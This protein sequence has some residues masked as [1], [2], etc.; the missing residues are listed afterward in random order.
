MSILF[1]IFLLKI[2]VSLIAIVAPFLFWSAER[3]GARL[4]IDAAS[5]LFFRLY[6][7]A[8]LALL[9]GYAGGAVE[10]WRGEFPW[11]IVFMG[12]VSNLG[13]AMV[14]IANGG[15]K[16]MPFSTVFFGGVGAALLWAA[17]NPA[18]SATRLIA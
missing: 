1:L 9:V 13:G 3:I 17:L 11:P 5:P 18:A 2:F 7:I 16:T 8:I 10:V 12:I 4:S 14:L 6:A 15:A